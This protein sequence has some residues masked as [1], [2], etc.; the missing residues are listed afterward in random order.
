[1]NQVTSY[2]PEFYK[3]IER[4]STIGA[5]KIIPLVLKNISDRGWKIKSILDV[6]CGT[7]SW[8]KVAK[9][10]DSEIRIKGIDFDVPPESLLIE[11]EEFEIVNLRS[12]FFIGQS[13]GYDLTISLEVAEHLEEEFSDSFIQSLTRTT[14]LI[15]FSAAIPHQKGTNHV[16]CQF[17]SYW[18]KKFVKYNF[19]CVDTIRP[20]IWN[21]EDIKFWYKQNIM[22]FYRMNK[23]KDLSFGKLNDGLYP[24]FYGADLVHP[25]MLKQVIEEKI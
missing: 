22:I 18:K 21:D 19:F 8:L 24:S 9:E 3:S 4:S 25:E 14:D 17:P 11:K 10:F 7:G 6:G 20:L 2:N 23:E 5:F 13:N 12:P 1:M 16:N 15:L